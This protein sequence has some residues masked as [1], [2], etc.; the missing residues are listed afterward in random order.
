MLVEAG[1]VSQAELQLRAGGPF[2]VSRPDRGT[3][4]AVALGRPGSRFAVGDRVRVR[5]WHPHGHTRAPRYVQGKRGVVA[6]IDPSANL[7]DVEAHGGGQVPEPTYSVRF[8]A[9]EL[10]GE[11]GAEG[12]TVYVD[13]WEYY[14]EEDR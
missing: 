5:E 14:L 6:R 4:P 3:P 7:P 11:G 12:E 1:V 8:S 2:P 13:L 9:K 10:W